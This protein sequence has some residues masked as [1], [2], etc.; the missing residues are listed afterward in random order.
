MALSDWVNRDDIP[1]KDE[2]AR[3][4]YRTKAQRIADVIQLNRPDKVP[5]WFQ[6]LGYFPCKYTGITFKKAAYDAKAWFEASKQVFIDFDVDMFFNP[7]STIQASGQAYEAMDTKN[8]KWPGHGVSENSSHQFVEGEYLKADEYDAFISDMADYV[9]RVYLP[10]VHGS[11]KPFSWLPPLAGIG[12]Y[13]PGTAQMFL[14][15]AVQHALSALNQAAMES[16]RW[17]M[18]AGAF[19]NEMAS[20]GFPLLIGSA[21]LAPF[22]VISD[23]F[24]GMRGSM[25]DMFRCP[26]KLLAAMERVLPMSIDSAI[27]L[28]KMSGNPGV[29]IALHRGGDA[30]MSKSQFERFYW[31]GVEQL[32]L[33]L[34]D[35]DLVPCLFIEGD[36]TSRLKYFAMLPKGKALAFFENS[37]IQKIKDVLGGT[38]ALS[39]G[40]PLSI[41]QLGTPDQVKSRAKE[42]IDI[43]GKDG[44]YIMGPKSI[45]DEA[46]P[47]LVRVWVDF[48]REYGIYGTK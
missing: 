14:Q 43:I 24:R 5:F 29:F 34:V 40:M 28:A 38:M 27:A 22:D 25:L 35:A 21:A 36:C 6:D 42:L 13:L 4:A 12:I 3:Q 9:W 37:D 44:G 45:M 48:T 8:M 39:G 31:P 33:A 10:R 17:G 47:E 30:F 41:L 19:L 18:A 20:L 1:F 16:A 46:N 26:N 23:F 11:L 15:P 7:A 2:T 32:I